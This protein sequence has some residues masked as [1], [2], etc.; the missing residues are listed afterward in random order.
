MP[1]SKQYSA[2]RRARAATSSTVRP[3]ASAHSTTPISTLPSCLRSRSLSSHKRKKTSLDCVTSPLGATMTPSSRQ[4]KSPR[5]QTTSPCPSPKVCR[6]LITS[7][8]TY[9]TDRDLTH[10]IYLREVS[11]RQKANLG[12]RLLIIKD[13][14]R[15]EV[16]SPRL[17]NT[18]GLFLSISLMIWSSLVRA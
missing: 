13:L 18:E 1:S 16:F 17:M 10:P 8:G 9:R 15:V 5:F 14:R 7:S 11:Y 3:S 6:I 4:S 12:S 2:I